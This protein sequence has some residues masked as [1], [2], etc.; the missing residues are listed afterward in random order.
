M[1]QL[2]FTWLKNLLN[3]FLALVMLFCLLYLVCNGVC[4]TCTMKHDFQSGDPISM[5]KRGSQQGQHGGQG[6]QGGEQQHQ[7]ITLHKS[8]NAYKPMLFQKD[9]DADDEARE[10]QVNDANETKVIYSFSLFLI[11]S[12][13]LSFYLSPPPPPPPPLFLPLPLCLELCKYML[14]ICNF[15]THVWASA[16]CIRS[17]I[18][19]PLLTD[20]QQFHYCTDSNPGTG[21]DNA[22]VLK[23][24][25]WRNATRPSH[26]RPAIAASTRRFQ[27]CF[28]PEYFDRLFVYLVLF[29]H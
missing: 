17:T 9:V 3:F 15:L 12:F 24:G 23:R 28:L 10:T 27:I 16:L 5:N 13:S 18:I 6:S 26:S 4:L 14:F 22:F 11:Y 25:M 29:M 19:P 7:E 21:A 20:P 8:E 2:W 1:Q